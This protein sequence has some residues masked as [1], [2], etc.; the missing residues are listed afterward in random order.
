[1][2]VIDVLGQFCALFGVKQLRVRWIFA[3]GGGEQAMNDD[4]GVSKKE[5]KKN[6]KSVSVGT[7]HKKD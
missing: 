2:P 3:D 6:Q 7:R 1:M 4:I 5:I